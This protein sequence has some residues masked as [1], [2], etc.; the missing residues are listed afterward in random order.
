MGGTPQCF[1][2]ML[3]VVLAKIGL[4][5]VQLNSTRLNKIIKFV[6]DQYGET[7]IN[8]EV[9]AM[10]CSAKVNSLKRNPVTVARQINHIFKQLWE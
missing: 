7:L 10:D 9:Y 6:P 3:L 8:E 1:H 4:F 5:V 2:N